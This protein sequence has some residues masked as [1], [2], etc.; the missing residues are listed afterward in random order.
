MTVG[1]AAG[2]LPGFKFAYLITLGQ[3][4]LWRKEMQM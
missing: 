4:Y 2:I 3:K 1:S